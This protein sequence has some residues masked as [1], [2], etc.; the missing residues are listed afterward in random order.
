MWHTRVHGDDISTKRLLLSLSGLVLVAFFIAAPRTVHA[1]TFSVLYTFCSQ[2]NCADGALPNS[3]LILDAQGN[4]YGTTLYGGTSGCAFHPCG[5]AFELTP[6]GIE[7]VLHNFGL[8]ID[9]GPE[10]L[11]WDKKGNLYGESGGEPAVG[12]VFE[13]TK[14]SFR[15][16][17]QFPQADPAQGNY[18]IGGLVMDAQ[19]NLFGTT[20]QGGANSC[21]F[22]SPNTC[23]TVFAVTPGGSHTVLHNFAGGTDGFQPVAGVILD[24]QGNLYG[25]T[26]Y[27]G[28]GQLCESGSS[29]GCG[30]VFKLT[31]DGTETI[32]YAFSGGT[33]GAIPTAGLVRDAKGDLYGTTQ[34]GGRG[35]G[36]LGNPGCGTVF[37][38]TRSGTLKVLYRFRGGMDGANPVG[39]LM[40]DAAGNL[41]GT[42]AEGGVGCNGY[43]CGTVFKLTPRRIKTTLYRFSGGADGGGPSS[44]LV[45]DAEGSLYGTA[46]GG[47]VSQ[48]CI[49]NN[50]RCGVVFKV[51]P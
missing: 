13:I 1:Q 40:L 27:G 46:A 12:V 51:I 9:A 35:T 37:K 30:V 21:L 10:G 4:L 31:P 8:G 3:S 47:A 26:A 7:T 23:G 34:H 25:T 49:F 41:Y 16:V 5:T 24:G 11:I 44:N 42:T 20:M 45:F 38:I 22:Q 14:S 15:D 50:G 43:G 32:L 29:N 33:D 2:P 19:G 6:G 18:P 39:G 36:C 48:N 17:Y 28:G